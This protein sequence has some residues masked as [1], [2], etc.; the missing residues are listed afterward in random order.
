MTG[1]VILSHGF[2]SGPEATKTVA[3]ARAAERLGWHTLCPDYRQHDGA[4]LGPAV[5]PRRRQLR[6]LCGQARGPLVLAGSSMGAFVSGLVS[7]EVDCAGLFLL[8]VPVR[9]P[10]HA[11]PFDCRAGIP[12]TLVHGHADELCPAQSVWALAHQRNLDLLMVADT[13]R[14]ANH[15]DWIAAQFGLFLQRLKS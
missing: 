4:G 10:D 11:E 13:H 5:G 2:E 12:T 14:L 15:V 7:C 9:M 8:A 1:T 6:A 3:M